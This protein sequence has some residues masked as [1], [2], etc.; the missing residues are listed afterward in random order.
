LTN[1]LGFYSASLQKQHTTD[2]QMSLHSG[3]LTWLILYQS[4]F[5]LT[6]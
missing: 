3:T 4:E 6:L 2:T 1:T 5:V